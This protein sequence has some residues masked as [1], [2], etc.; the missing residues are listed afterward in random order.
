MAELVQQAGVERYL[1]QQG[2]RGGADDADGPRPLEFDTR[3]FPIAQR[4]PGFVSRVGRLI[5]GS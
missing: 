2:W 1:Q 4:R 3:G 5:N